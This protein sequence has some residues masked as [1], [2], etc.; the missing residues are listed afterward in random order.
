MDFLTPKCCQP[1][2]RLPKGTTF[3]QNACFETSLL[4]FHAR[5]ASVGESGKNKK[6]RPYI[7]RIL[8]GALLLPIGTN[9][10]FRVRGRNQLCKVL[11]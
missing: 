5:V 2:C 9:L 3:R 11:S 8:P 1:S 7:S 6:G 4:K 10:G